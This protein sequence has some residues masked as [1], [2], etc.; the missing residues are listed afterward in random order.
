MVTKGDDL[1]TRSATP[2][3]L[4]VLHE[5][6]N[7]GLPISKRVRELSRVAPTWADGMLYPLLRHLERVGLITAEWRT[8]RDRNQR[9][10]Y[11]ITPLGRNT[12]AQ[13]APE[14]THRRQG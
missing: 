12:A 10:F 3:V 13:P 5:G 8:L 11:A 7:Y 4:T 1:T 6:A 14:D 2:A 9:R